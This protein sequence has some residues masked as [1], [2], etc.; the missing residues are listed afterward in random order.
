MA[1]ILK[2]GALNKAY[3]WEDTCD[4]CGSRL[5]L[6]SG[7]DKY[8][9]PDVMRSGDCGAYFMF[10]HYVCPVCSEE[11]KTYIDKQGG[12]SNINNDEARARALRGG[13]K[14]KWTALTREDLESLEEV[15][16]GD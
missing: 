11:Q 5:K 14:C 8:M 6:Y 15:E 16:S 1:K 3:V 12:H 10:I 13:T 2:R 9:D 4:C 7:N